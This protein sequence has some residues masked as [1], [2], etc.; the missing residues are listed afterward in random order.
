MIDPASAEKHKKHPL[1]VVI[2]DV[3]VHRFLFF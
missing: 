3:V 2:G 1:V